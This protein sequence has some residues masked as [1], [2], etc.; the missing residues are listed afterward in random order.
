M[1]SSFLS[2]CPRTQPLWQIASK[3]IRD[4][5]TLLNEARFRKEKRNMTRVDMG[6]VDEARLGFVYYSGTDSLCILE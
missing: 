3:Y 2:Q 4:E 1:Q 5:L 6:E